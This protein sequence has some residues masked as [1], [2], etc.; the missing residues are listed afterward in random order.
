MNHVNHFYNHLHTDS[1]RWWSQND[2]FIQNL[3]RFAKQNLSGPMILSMFRIYQFYNC[4]VA[5]TFGDQCFGEMA[6]DWQQVVLSY[7]LR[8]LSAK[9]ITGKEDVIRKALF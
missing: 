7:L 4:S 9:R 3:V 2:F 6:T 1:T 5:G 8:N